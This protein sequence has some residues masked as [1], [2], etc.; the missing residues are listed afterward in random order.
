MSIVKT[1]Q[2]LECGEITDGGME[3]CS[4]CTERY[5]EDDLDDF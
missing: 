1:W 2:C 3:L 5:S 4:M